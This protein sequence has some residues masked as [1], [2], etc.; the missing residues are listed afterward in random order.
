MVQE[1]AWRIRL[2]L[3]A[4]DSAGLRER[5]AAAV[6]AQLPDDLQL[7]VV[8]RDAIERVPGEKT[9]VVL[10]ELDRARQESR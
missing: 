6:R 10:S 7:E 1:D 9:R 5:V 2:E 3:A 8:S 4:P